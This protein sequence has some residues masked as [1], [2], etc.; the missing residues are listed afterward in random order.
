MKGGCGGAGVSSF[1]QGK[2]RENKKKWPQG[3]LKNSFFTERIAKPETVCP[4]KRKSHHPWT[5]LKGIVMVLRDMVVGGI[6]GGG[7]MDSLLV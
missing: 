6:G 2:K 1:S 3:G 7:L 4:G 5:N